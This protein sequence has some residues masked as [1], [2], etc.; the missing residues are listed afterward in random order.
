MSLV[1]SNPQPP[2]RVAYDVIRKFIQTN[3][4]YDGGHLMDVQAEE[5]T[6]LLSDAGVLVTPQASSAERSEEEVLHRIRQVLHD[7]NLGCAEQPGKH[8]KVAREIFELVGRFAPTPSATPA[9]VVQY[10]SLLD[11][12][13]RLKVPVTPVGGVVT[14]MAEAFVD[15]LG[16]NGIEV[17]RD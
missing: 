16:R 15:F 13:A 8:D 2:K 6:I 7:N 4:G 1:S 14:Y 17:A 5:L 10:G 9:P 11:W 3:V 12:V